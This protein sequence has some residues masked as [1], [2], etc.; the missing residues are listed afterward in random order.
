MSQMRFLL[1]FM[2]RTL[3]FKLYI[4]YAVFRGHTMSSVT[5]MLSWEHL[6]LAIKFLVALSTRD[7]MQEI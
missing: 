5:V 4:L 3:Q 7:M 1:Y 2:Q 6:S